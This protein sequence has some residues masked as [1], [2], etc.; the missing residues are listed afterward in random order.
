[1]DFWGEHVSSFE[2]DLLVYPLG[3]LVDNDYHYYYYDDSDDSYYND[4]VIEV[5]E[6]DGKVV[7]FGDEEFNR[8]LEC[9]YTDDNNAFET[10]EELKER[11]VLNME[12]DRLEHEYNVMIRRRLENEENGIFIPEDY[13]DYSDYEF[14]V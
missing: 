5:S 6:S 14:D 12:Y 2:D 1:M 8:L 10:E 13:S 3:E 4:S 7:N 11:H 9:N